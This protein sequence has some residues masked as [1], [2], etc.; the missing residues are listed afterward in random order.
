MRKESSG[1]KKAQ[2]LEKLP[3][4]LFAQLDEA[5][6]KLEEKGVDVIDLGV[7]DPDVPTPSPIIDRLV[8]AA[9]DPQNHRYPPYEGL[10]SF[11]EEVA[12]WYL[13][14]FGV[15]LDP[16]K[17]VMTLIGSKEGIAH[18]CLGLLDPGDLAL[19]PEP[20]YPVY[21]AG[22]I[23]AGAQPY[24]M[25]LLEDNGFLPSL[26]D[27]NPEV[28]LQA[29]LMWI[30]YPNNPTAATVDV[31]FFREAVEFARRYNIVLCHDLAYSELSYDGYRAPSLLQVE[32]AKEIAVE[33]HSLSKSFCMTG[34]RI[35][36]AVGNKDLLGAL[37]GVKTNIDSGVFQAVQEAGEEALRMGEE[38]ISRIREIYRRRRDFFV[39]GLKDLGWEVSLPRATFYL[40]IKVPENGSSFDFARTLLEK[41]GIVVTPGVGFGPSGEGYIRVALT[42][43]EERLKE[44]LDRLEKVKS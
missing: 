11:R 19:V 33:F 20:A 4:Y 43:S 29:K 7:G 37:K 14:R 34:W 9:K 41:C 8:K 6:R 3:V 12:R 27:I 38:L 40:W 13:R 22:V 28:A 32:G 17:E 2:R 25:P 18:I 21:Q 30:N 10:L 15:S 23:F 42:V 16:E 36:F 35:G 5:K 31:D 26:G 24:Y 39:Q 44:A 1:F